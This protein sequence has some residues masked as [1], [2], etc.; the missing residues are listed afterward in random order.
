M[1]N[2]NWD[3]VDWYSDSSKA[4]NT[5][6]WAPVTSLEDGLTMIAD[7]QNE[8][9]HVEHLYNTYTT[10]LDKLTDTWE[11]IFV[12]NGANDGSVEK[13]NSINTRDNVRVCW[14]EKGGW[15]R[16]VK[17]GLAEGKGKYLCYT[18]SA[19]TDIDDLILILNYARVN[20]DNVV[21]ATRI[22]REKLVR[23]IGSTLYNFQ[24]RLLYK[25][26]IWD[27]NGTPKV[28][29]Q[30]IYKDLDIT[31]DDDLID[32]EVIIKCNLALR[33]PAEIYGSTFEGAGIVP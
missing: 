20:N 27:V 28:I 1:P 23:K 10:H 19:R 29:P 5:L 22:I 8:V 14:L 2:R 11:L 26:P 30:H 15:G 6:D 25:V 3:V 12:V 31:S 7:W 32:A 16:A 33:D 9:A 21:K 24:C 13:L 4:Q 18:N 17:Y